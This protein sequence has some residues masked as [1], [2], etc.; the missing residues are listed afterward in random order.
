MISI[1]DQLSPEYRDM[2]TLAASLV[3]ALKIEMKERGWSG[4]KILDAEYFDDDDPPRLLINIGPGHG[5]LS[6]AAVSAFIKEKRAAE[7]QAG[8]AA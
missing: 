1:C 5:A 7:R 3:G 8:E 4:A 6:V 2:K